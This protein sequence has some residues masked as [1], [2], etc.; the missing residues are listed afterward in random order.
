MSR[1]PGYYE[2]LGQFTLKKYL[3]LVMFLDHAKRSRLIL[4]D[5]CLFCKDS[6]FKVRR[7]IITHKLA[8]LDNK[9]IFGGSFLQKTSPFLTLSCI[10]KVLT[11]HLNIA[12]G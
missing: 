10:S 8:A 7:I 4:E 5:P 11:L 9:H 2:A 6:E 1:L 12:Y 3:M